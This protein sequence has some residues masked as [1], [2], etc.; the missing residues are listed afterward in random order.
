MPLKKLGD[1]WRYNAHPSWLKRLLFL[2]V[3][4]LVNLGYRTRLEPEHMCEEPTVQTSRLIGNLEPAWQEQLKK[5]KPDLKR[6]LLRGNGHAFIYTG[7][8][9]LFAQACS[10]AGPLLLRRIVGGLQCHA[11]EAKVQ[12]KAPNA[13]LGCQP[14]NELY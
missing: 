4:P 11:A 1:G 5:P 9:Y 12:V 8:L 3:D 6:A 13:D 7:V 14:F 2:D 10:L